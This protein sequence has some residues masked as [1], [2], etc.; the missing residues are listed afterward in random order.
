MENLIL[1]FFIFI[2]IQ[3]SKCNEDSKIVFVY[4]YVRHGARSPLFADGNTEYID[5]FGTKWEG[6][7]LL[8]L[9][10]RREHYVIGIQNRKKYSSLINFDKFD[11]N[12]I[13]IYTTNTGRT[14]QSIQAE[15]Q[16]MYLPGTLEKLSNEQLAVALPPIENLPQEVI[17][18]AETLDN[19]TIIYGI[20][21][22]PI[23]FVSPTK[24][25]L[26]KA[27]NCPYMAKYQEELVKKSKKRVDEFLKE[28]DQKFGEQLQ[29]FL[30]KPNRD[31]MFDFDFV[32]LYF[33]DEVISN[34]YD[35]NNFT[36]FI[37]QTDINITEFLEYNKESKNI[38]IFHQNVDEQ[39]GVMAASPLMK[40][41]I[42]YMD[43]IIN[44]KTKS[45]KMVMFGGHDDTMNCVLYFMQNVFNIPIEFIPFAASIYFELHKKGTN[46][47]YVEYIFD[48]KSLLTK[49]YNS[50]KNKVLEKIWSEEKINNFCYPKEESQ[51]DKTGNDSNN[52]TYK[53]ATL[54][55]SITNAIFF[56]LTIVFIFLSIHYRK[57]SKT[58]LDISAKNEP[59]LSEMN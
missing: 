51:N 9:V 3:V 47:Y 25:L 16:A 11:I 32:E 57:K 10:G 52:E 21:V 48:G 17:T 6:P 23:Q 29:K 13:Q 50:F 49:D 42:N 28:N 14:I 22:F 36:D 30:N 46:D 31:F 59:I 44:N 20:N 12:E 2:L 45:P 18:E 55:L 41:L 24:Y 8:T 19:E 38:Y 54:I 40:D 27:E 34:H 37:N 26:N 5:H 53:N 35:G 4:E 58:S 33:A 43:D 39:G 56:V 1:L 15:L 7:A